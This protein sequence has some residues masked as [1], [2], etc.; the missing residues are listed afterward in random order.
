M[1]W[2]RITGHTKKMNEHAPIGAKPKPAVKDAVVLY[3][4]GPQDLDRKV[5][6]KSGFRS[7]NLIAV[8]ID[9]QL[10]RT[11]RSEGKIAI[12]GDFVD[13]VGNWT[14]RDK[15]TVIYADFCGGLEK[16][17]YRLRYAIS[18]MAHSH[19][20]DEMA[21]FIVAINMLHGRDK[22]SD[23]LREMRKAFGAEDVVRYADSRI[24]LDKDPLHRGRL[25][26]MSTWLGMALSQKLTRQTA[27]TMFDGMMSWMRPEFLQYRSGSQYMD[28]VIFYERAVGALGAHL[29][30]SDGSIEVPSMEDFKNT[31]LRGQI[32]ACMA[33]RTL[34]L[35]A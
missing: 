21:A 23:Q 10:V 11:M 15:P 6:I 5:A 12:H 18:A 29:G 35:A 13:V 20:F 31:K 33:H 3:L 22:W 8:D 2:N 7:G 25:F 24:G 28:S 9:K 32:A 34:R 14:H 17:I 27:K 19:G 30:P 26:I 16:N 4:A 1:L